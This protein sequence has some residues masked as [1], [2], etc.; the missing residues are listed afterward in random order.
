LGPDHY[1]LLDY[2]WGQWMLY[3]EDALATILDAEALLEQLPKDEDL[4]TDG[5]V[6]FS[7][8]IPTKAGLV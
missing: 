2:Q 1:P 8:T 3:E 5:L 6:L 4:P 7:G